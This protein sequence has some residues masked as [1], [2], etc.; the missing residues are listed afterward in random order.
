VVNIV[1]EYKQ[2]QVG[3]QTKEKLLKAK[4]LGKTWDA[5]LLGLIAKK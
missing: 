3:S 4:P 1:T 2:I 5:F